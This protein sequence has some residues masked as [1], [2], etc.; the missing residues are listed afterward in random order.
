MA[1]QIRH[2]EN[3]GA[4]EAQQLAESVWQW[5]D[6][7]CPVFMYHV[8]QLDRQISKGG[9]LWQAQSET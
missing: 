2:V 3:I 4:G 5:L 1:A 9:N 6:G 7:L 8:T